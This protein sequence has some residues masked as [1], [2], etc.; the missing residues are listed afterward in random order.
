MVGLVLQVGLSVDIGIMAAASRMLWSFARDRGFPGR[1]IS[2][3]PN[4]TSQPP[5]QHE[6]HLCQVDGKT[7]IPFIAIFTTTVLS[8]ILSFISIG[9]PV[10]FNDVVSLTLASL[11]AS[12]FV[13]CA[14][15]LWRRITGSVKTPDQ[16]SS[17]LDQR[18]RA[19]SNSS[20]LCREP[21]LG[22]MESTGS[23]GHGDQ[24][25]WLHLSPDCRY[26]CLLPADQG[27]PCPNDEIQQFGGS[28][29][30]FGALYYVF[31]AR[32]TYDGPIV[33]TR[34]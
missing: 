10:A 31:W 6:Q 13:V 2:K 20:R 19:N 14:L 21:H 28:V 15:L 23:C 26:L 29:A 30:I 1:Y 22:P 12:Y 27:S 34:S 25:L 18:H 7:K 8:V 5:L 9:S 33:G 24:R 11:Y 3:V 4:S 16:V 17:S 32:G